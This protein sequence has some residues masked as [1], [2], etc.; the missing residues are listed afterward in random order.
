MEQR[1]TR[2]GPLLL[3][4][5]LVSCPKQNLQPLAIERLF[6]TCLT[7]PPT[8]LG[9]LSL[10]LSLQR[11]KMATCTQYGGLFSSLAIGTN[12]SKRGVSSR[13]QS[14]VLKPL[15]TGISEAGLGQQDG[16]ADTGIGCRSLRTCVQTH[17]GGETP[18]PS[19]PSD[20]Q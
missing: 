5:H 7:P 2:G 17:V 20:L 15:E 18:F 1:Q 13:T 4:A 3:S 6:G 16:S 9:K 14:K 19:L 11:D 8:I 10:L 12:D